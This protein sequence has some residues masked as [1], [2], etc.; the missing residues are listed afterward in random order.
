MIEPLFEMGRTLATAGVMAVLEELGQ[1]DLL[2]SVLHR[3]CYGDWGDV[4]EDDWRANE[5]ALQDNERLMSLYKVDSGLTLWV[6]TEADR[7][8]TT[9]MLPK[10]Y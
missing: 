8:Q 2:Q 3:H 1:Q 9:V 6:I 4:D 7:S 5:Q 10:E